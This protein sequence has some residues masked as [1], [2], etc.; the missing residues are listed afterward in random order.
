MQKKVI[1]GLCQGACDV[2]VDVEDGRI[3]KV[4]ADK[5]SPRGRL[6]PRAARAPEA[7]YGEARIL[8][9]MVREGER[10]EG[11]LRAV[12]WDEALDRAAE[13]IRGVIDRHGARA[14]ATYFGRG[15]LGTPVARLQR[16]KEAFAGRL[17][18]PNDTSCSSICNLS[19]NTI[20][21][22]TTFGLATRQM[23]FDIEHADVIV[24]W[25]K[26]PASDEGPRLLL[27]RI[28]AA[29]ERGAKLVVVDPR[30]TGIG[31]LADWWVPVRPGSDG[32]LAL[33]LLKVIV[34]DG[35]YDK[36]FVRDFTRGFDELAAYLDALSLET[37][38][39]QCGISVADIRALA[40]LLASTT[41]APLV[42]YTGIEYQ[43]S[44]L[45][46]ARAIWTLWAI[47][48]KL[49]AEG[50]VFFRMKGVGPFKAFSLDALPEGADEPFGA[51]EFPLFYRYIGQADFIRFPRA[52]LDDDPYPVRG[53]LISGGSPAT[54]FPDSATWKRA[55]AKLECLIVVD[56]FNTEECRW[57]DVV[58]PAASLFET[59]RLA[60][61]P[62]GAFAR[63]AVVP[64]AGEARN[65]VLIMAGIAR[66]LGTGE[67]L[68]RDE[69]ELR[70]WMVAGAQTSYTDM[71]TRTVPEDA[72]FRKYTA[73]TLRV[74]GQPGFPTPSGKFEIASCVL[75]EHGIEPLP[76]YVD[77]YDFTGQDAREWPFLL[78]TGARDDARMGA[79]GANI[80][81][82]AKLDD[83]HAELCAQDAAELG[84]ADGDKVRVSTVYGSLVLPVRI[85]GLARGAVHLP[86]GGG[87]S[88]MP[89]AWR[90]GNCND[91]ASLDAVDPDTGFVLIKTLPCKV[92]KVE[93]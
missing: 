13:L 84:V 86:H 68:P 29:K 52:V 43:A 65:D 91:L 79:F 11:R 48:G 74:D 76:K 69:G 42:F 87:S 41:R 51:R 25:G 35:R 20:V 34:E 77:I 12:S 71:W 19:A 53:L 16:G 9:P 93:E 57:A 39:A 44:A 73:G 49:D 38:S 36:D 78:S 6:C 70:E 46:N 5:D 63:D 3:A 55:Y 21:P 61:G 85:A 45:Q 83:P 31:Q 4:R 82:I 26:N 33:A 7:L 2:V 59:P 30:Q 10:G 47:T 56:R 62:N 81:G 58:L 88:Y 22:Q 8:H 92:E 24:C 75:A 18:S 54:T 60:W 14:F 27:K 64:P 37:L 28:K 72:E 90:D 66:R 32:A 89:P 67:G 17:G 80:P 40:D 1:C 23:L 15:I 50:G